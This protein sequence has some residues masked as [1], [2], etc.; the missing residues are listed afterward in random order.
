MCRNVS[1]LLFH[2]PPSLEDLLLRGAF[3]SAG[4]HTYCSLN[5]LLRP[6][7]GDHHRWALILCF[8]NMPHIPIML[9]SALPWAGGPKLQLCER[10]GLLLFPAHPLPCSLPLTLLKTS[11]P[12]LLDSVSA[13]VSTQHPTVMPHC[14]RLCFNTFWEHFPATAYHVFILRWVGLI[15]KG[16][17]VW[18]FMQGKQI[19]DS[20]ST[21]VKKRSFLLTHSDE[22]Y[23]ILLFSLHSCIT[24]WK[25]VWKWAIWKLSKQFSH[26]G[27]DI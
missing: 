27:I 24:R 7:Y 2:S 18:K 19:D 1:F 23:N 15:I 6:T 16:F 5:Q 25:L 11:P 8:T 26:I 22:A 12:S 10:L 9:D 14:K 20:Y 4:T 17:G 3:P 21:N 13:A